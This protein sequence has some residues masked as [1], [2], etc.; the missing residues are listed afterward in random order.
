MLIKGYHDEIRKIND[1]DINLAK[2]LIKIAFPEENDLD[3]FKLFGSKVIMCDNYEVALS[4]GDRFYNV[5]T[6]CFFLKG[7]EKRRWMYRLFYCKGE[8]EVEKWRYVNPNTNLAYDGDLDFDLTT[9][10]ILE[11]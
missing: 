8:G 1:T 9:L 2:T 3:H 6:Y 10:P 7:E 11:N 5:N 4:F